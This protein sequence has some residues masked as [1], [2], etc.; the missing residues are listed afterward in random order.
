MVDLAD[1]QT[2]EYPLSNLRFPFPDAP[3]PGERISVLPG[4]DWVRLPLPFALD[5][6]NCWYLYGEGGGS[7]ISGESRDDGGRGTGGRIGRDDGGD[8][9]ID[10][11]LNTPA[12]HACWQAIFKSQPLPQQLLV[13]HFHP[14]HSGLAGWFAEKGVRVIS[15][16]IEMDIARRIYA[17]SDAENVERQLAWYQQHGIPEQALAKASQRGNTFRKGTVKP[18]QQLR[19]VRA[20]DK[21]TF[22]GQEYEVLTGRGHA[23]DMIMLYSESQKLLIAADQILP[24]ISPNISLMPGL[25][26][27][28]PLA[29][30]LSDLDGLLKLP[31]ET[32]VLPS[33][34]LPFYGLR[35]RIKAL[36]LHHEERL[37]Q[38]HAAL[39]EPTTACAL[40][41]VLFSRELDAQQLYFA[42]G[43]TV[44]H[45]QYLKNQSLVESEERAGVMYFRAV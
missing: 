17:Q 38:I 16:E 15:S 3:A 25:P 8:V 32:L 11:G 40:F 10:S 5:H 33:H 39:G 41:P 26:S 20:S 1:H 23:P 12:I 9:L 34:G 21:L 24:S 45:L 6:V 22:A 27:A 13:T 30:F 43:E 42:L 18:P 7:S 19:Y 14:D 44:A 29:D 4:L 35:E 37:E 36:Q 28:D 2:E 31:E